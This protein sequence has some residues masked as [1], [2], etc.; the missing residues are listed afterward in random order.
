MTL[1][2]IARADDGGLGAQTLEAWRHLQP[3]KTLIVLTDHESRGRAHP[4][5]FNTGE[6]RTT[7]WMP[8]RRDLVWLFDGIRTLYSAETF[9][10]AHAAAQRAGIRTVL[11]ANPEM[12]AGDAPDVTLAATG[13][14]LDLLHEPRVLPFPVARD[15]LPFRRR[16]HATTLYHVTS[17]AMRDRNGTQLLL[18][19]LDHIT[20]PCRLL[21]RGGTPQTVRHG[22]VDV[23]WL[24]HY[25]GPY[26]QAWPDDADVLVL[27]RRFGGL[28][29]PMQEAASL[30]M[31]VVTLDIDPQ[32]DW[33]PD[34]VPATVSETARMKGGRVDVADADPRDLAT[35]INQLLANPTLVAELSDHSNRWAGTISWDRLLPQYQEILAVPPRTPSTTPT[36]A[37]VSV[38]LPWRDGCDHRAKA[39]EWILDRYHQHHPDWQIVEGSCDDDAPWSKGAA[40]DEAL[41]AATGDVLVIADADCWVD[42]EILAHAA[43]IA[44]DRNRWVVPHSR[45]HRLDE[46]STEQIYDGAPLRRRS[47]RL[48]K[49]TYEGF[50]GGGLVAL[51]RSS[52]ETV[53]MDRRFAGWGGEDQCF[54]WALDTLVGPH[55]RLNG[56]LW[57]LY[58][59]HA[60][61][62]R[63][64]VDSSIELVAAYRAARGVPR[65]MR[66]V[67]DGTDPEP[68]E[69][70]PTPVTFSAPPYVRTV[71]MPTKVVRFRTGTYTT[72]DPDEAVFLR[73]LTHITEVDVGS[74]PADG[75]RRDDHAPV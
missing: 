68:A 67:L 34:L 75:A 29:L 42:P 44:S 30:G 10:G 51:H 15:R 58:H 37:T 60:L 23:E 66:A 4:E 3:A 1:G 31:P 17:N 38:I 18:A 12:H 7:P 40:V 6:V 55:T 62:S 14:R 61:P 19:A 45:V 26:W 21:I 25:D 2:L 41:A 16:T 35:R 56:D 47:F 63:R 36:S 22:H 69:P 43:G 74:D 54:G 20:S 9:Y 53:H 8:T 70:L 59:P 71:R 33:F 73:G 39:R 49:P 50:A 65:L 57:H 46:R 48:D 52:Y 32:H 27:P 24:G 11:H 72:R 5:R 28:C 64:M 13:W